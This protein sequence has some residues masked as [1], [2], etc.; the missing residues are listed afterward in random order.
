MFFPVQQK[1]PGRHGHPSVHLWFPEAQKFGARKNGR[2]QKEQNLENNFEI[3]QMCLKLY[4]FMK[5]LK[6]NLRYKY[7]VQKLNRILERG[8]TN[9]CLILK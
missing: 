6:D 2:I 5:M 7:Q 1:P 9:D 4:W 3:N 8:W